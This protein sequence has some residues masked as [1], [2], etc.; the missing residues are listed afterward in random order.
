MCNKHHD[1]V[2]P[3]MSENILYINQFKYVFKDFIRLKE[4][5]NI[6]RIKLKIIRNGWNKINNLISKLEIDKLSWYLNFYELI[7]ILWI[8]NM[9]N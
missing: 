4:N 8:K 5:S 3:E 7:M 9:L 2:Q 1:A 6:Y